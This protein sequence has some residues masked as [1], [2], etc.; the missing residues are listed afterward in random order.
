MKRHFVRRG[1]MSQPV[2]ASPA[3][4]SVLSTAIFI[5]IAVA[6]TPAAPPSFDVVSIR[7]ADLPT[8]ETMRSGQFRTG[9][10][11]SGGTADFQF[12]TLADLLP[13]AYRV[14]SFQVIGPSSL[15]ES[16][17]NIRA[18]LADGAS[19]DQVPEMVQAMLVDRFKLAIHHEKRELPVYELVVLKGGP[20]L[21]PADAPDA[22]SANTTAATLG[23]P[24]LFPF[25]GPP[26]GRGPD[27]GPPNGDG[28]GGGR[29]AAFKSADGTVRM[30]PDENCGMRLEFTQLTMS[31]LADTLTPF[32]DRP[33]IDGTSVKGS[34]K[35]SLKLPMEIMFAMMQNQIRNANLPP[36]G[37]GFG[38][39]GGGPGGPGGP[40]GCDPG[41]AL[42]GNS[43]TSNAAL[44]QAIQKLGLK[45][46]TKKAPF[47]AIIV[48]HVEKTPSDN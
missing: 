35:A 33:V 48:D 32:L 18:K 12:V 44:F 36:P 3:A 43:D 42:G 15:R 26:G 20:K 40:G 10:T 25:G 39:P 37:G 9:T 22:A 38:G 16:R 23:P 45:L 34:Y 46:Q 7:S 27:G 2:K 1:S 19:Q 41:Q 21:E 13:Y 30:S 14:K 31:G 29:G 4:G 5:G 6:Q 11:I 28:R 24:G 47:D 8:P 17:W